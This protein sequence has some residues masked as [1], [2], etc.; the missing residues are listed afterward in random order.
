MLSV[1]DAPSTNNITVTYRKSL[2]DI[3]QFISSVEMQANQTYSIKMIVN[4]STQTITLV[5]DG[6]SETSLPFIDP[7]PLFSSS[8]TTFIGYLTN[9]QPSYSISEI[10][11]YVVST[12]QAPTSAPTQ[13]PTA[14]PT[15]SPTASPITPTAAP[16][17]SPTSAP[18]QSP[19]SAPTYPPLLDNWFISNYVL[20]DYKKCIENPVYISQNIVGSSMDAGK[21]CNY[22]SNC[23]AI[24]YDQEDP[25]N[26]SLLSACGKT[27]YD[28][29]I[30]YLEKDPNAP[31]PLTGFPFP[32]I[33]D[34]RDPTTFNVDIDPLND[35]DLRSK[36]LTFYFRMQYFGGRFSSG[37]DTS[38]Y[39]SIIS[40]GGFNLY[41]SE[42]GNQL[43]GMRFGSDNTRLTT[44]YQFPATGFSSTIFKLTIN[45]RTL[46]TELE[47]SQQFP[48]G[49]PTQT[50]S[51]QFVLSSSAI[52]N[53]LNSVPYKLGWRWDYPIVD[54]P[55]YAFTDF[56]ATIEEAPQTAAPTF[57]PTSSP[58]SAPTQS[59]TTSPT[60]APTSSPTSAP[61]QS[62]TTSP[63][64]S[65]TSAPTF[66][67]LDLDSYL[68]SN[69]PNEEVGRGCTTNPV[70]ISQ[71]VVGSITDGAT[72]CN[73]D[74]NCIAFEYSRD[75]PSNTYS[76][77]S[78]CDQ[79]GN[80]TNAD[81]YFTKDF[82]LPLPISGFPTSVIRNPSNFSVDW[83][84]YGDGFTNISSSNFSKVLI[85]ECDF[86]IQDKVW[87]EGRN[88][89]GSK[90]FKTG[91]IL[92]SV[93]DQTLCFPDPASNVCQ[94]VCTVGGYKFRTTYAIT[95]NGYIGANVIYTRIR[96]EVNYADF[97][98]SIKIGN[99]PIEKSGQ[100]PITGSIFPGNNTQLGYEWDTSFFG[101][102][103]RY[104]ID[105]VE[106]YTQ[107]E[108][109][110]FSPLVPCVGQNCNTLNLGLNPGCCYSTSQTVTVNWPP[111]DRSVDP[112][113]IKFQLK[114]GQV[115]LPNNYEIIRAST[116]GIG[117]RETGFIVFSSGGKFIFRG[118]CNDSN[119]ELCQLT[120]DTI[121]GL[122]EYNFE[123]LLD[124]PN[125]NVSLVINGNNYG[126]CT[127]CCGAQTTCGVL[128]P[129]YDDNYVGFQT[130]DTWL[131][132]SNNFVIMED[133][134][135]D[136]EF[137]LKNIEIQKSMGGFN[138]TQSVGL[139][140]YS[141]CFGGTLDTNF[142]DSAFECE[143]DCKNNPD[144]IAYIYN[145]CDILT[146]QQCGNYNYCELSQPSTCLQK[147]F[148]EIGARRGSVGF[149]GDN[150]CERSWSTVIDGLDEQCETTY[151]CKFASSGFNNFCLNWDDSSSGNNSS[152]TLDFDNNNCGNIFNCDK[153]PGTITQQSICQA[154]GY[155]WVNNECTGSPT[156]NTPDFEAYCRQ[157][158]NDQNDCQVLGADYCIWSPPGQT[159]QCVDVC[160]QN[161]NP[162]ACENQ[163]IRTQNSCEW[164][165]NTNNSGE[166]C[167]NKNFTACKYNTN[168][169]C[170]DVL[171]RDSSKVC[172]LKSNCDNPSGN[173]LS[174][175][176]YIS[177]PQYSYNS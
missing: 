23:I 105:N 121:S 92:L 176:V 174:Q 145:Y 61:T 66:F 65:P 25:D 163:K 64:F 116:N 62:P 142:A 20:D 60:F 85:F 118:L 122:K 114:L 47:I 28:D 96:L 131:G 17:Q 149:N 81:V 68:V 167:A 88:M 93:R 44:N 103:P 106:T 14:S 12:Y 74:E 130:P 162:T 133:N 56:R 172:T 2:N 158:N 173:D 43:I 110:S 101:S 168:S 50:Y 45:Y 137:N 119:C 58:T 95:A 143:Q 102:E 152:S 16:T 30:T 124:Y 84:P 39:T 54:E 112:L 70:Y 161:N 164:I 113:L 7:L 38:F 138:L 6:N 171:P 140:E 5:I 46:V 157:F 63:T 75:G 79:V 29:S 8:S 87:D 18:T 177:V 49:L 126:A 55:K 129:C 135:F 42:A 41:M 52:P 69:F 34:L 35:N 100:F 98:I 166:V 40:G 170:R 169:F 27:G 154:S 94:L 15:Q 26:Y 120:G 82:N 99:N 33:P 151:G 37:F 24:E 48:T 4:Y 80:D 83:D 139:K 90:I 150:D 153:D 10:G 134:S 123:I 160:G 109:T 13:S 165:S 155:S 108:A 71:E 136:G 67:P 111:I 9:N 125:R 77:L 59:P 89:E 31:I 76:L 57:A 147:D 32:G 36:I 146:N 72:E 91:G 78:G 11:A 144:C 97:T 86:A 159:G 51:Q 73:K 21:A 19:T 132:T 3:E 128:E 104:S 22:D 53:D 127:T 156:G 115:T 175:R 1:K 141:T 148:D 107:I 117:T